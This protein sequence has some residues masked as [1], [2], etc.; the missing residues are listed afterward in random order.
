MI[1][2]LVGRLGATSVSGKF[3]G[4]VFDQEWDLRFGQKGKA[5][6]LVKR[7]QDLLLEDTRE[8]GTLKGNSLPTASSCTTS[9]TYLGRR[10]GDNRR[11]HH[12]S[13]TRRAVVPSHRSRSDIINIFS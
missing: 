13:A 5:K 7:Q 2:E 3:K 8:K 11:T 4:S 12:A 1:P 10:L 6:P 9:C